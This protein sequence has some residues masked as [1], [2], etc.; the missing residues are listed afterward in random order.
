[1]T[2]LNVDGQTIEISNKDKLFFP[3]A[4]ITKGDLID[5]YRRIAETILPYMKE[6]PLSMRRFPEGIEGEGFYQTEAS[7]G[8]L[9]GLD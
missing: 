5:Y 3:D 1:M 8:L 2:K 7:T 9:P 4:G 6:R